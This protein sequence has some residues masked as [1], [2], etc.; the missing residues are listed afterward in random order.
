[1]KGTVLSAA[2]F[3]HVPADEDHQNDDGQDDD[4]QDVFKDNDD[5]EHGGKAKE[6]EE[7]RSPDATFPHGVEDVGQGDEK[8]VRAGPGILIGDGAV[9]DKPACEIN[10]PG[11]DHK[12]A[13]ALL[14][15]DATDEGHDR[16]IALER[17]GRSR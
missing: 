1:M 4:G 13:V 17:K 5:R 9:L 2:E 11:P 7:E 15:I 16:L 12:V 8:Q 14:H 10:V 3:F 6:Q